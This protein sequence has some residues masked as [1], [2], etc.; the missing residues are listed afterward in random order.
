MCH[1]E[2]H[3]SEDCAVDSQ[4]FLIDDKGKRLRIDGHQVTDEHR[5]LIIALTTDMNGDRATACTVACPMEATSFGTRD[6]LLAEAWSRITDEPDTYVKKVY[7]Q[8]EVGGT[9]V[10]YVTSV[11]FEKLGFMTKLE[12]TPLPEKTWNVLKHIP[13]VVITAGVA[14]GAVYWITN[15][16]D[17]VRRFEEQHQQSQHTNE[18]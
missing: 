13:D 11:P 17:E 3:I 8:H 4:G 15:R 18:K 16:R 10:F 12:Y 9:S 6:E 14:L 7:G 1:A 2:R 5:D